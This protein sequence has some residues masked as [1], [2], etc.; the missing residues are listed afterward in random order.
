MLCKIVFLLLS[1]FTVGGCASQP[2]KS[3]SESKSGE[4]KEIP[5]AGRQSMLVS[6][7]NGNEVETIIAQDVLLEVSSIVREFYSNAEPV[8]LYLED[9]ELN[10]LMAKATGFSIKF[11][12]PLQFGDG[13]NN[14]NYILFFTE[15]R[16]RNTD[17][18]SDIY[19]LTAIG[20]EDLIRS[21]FIV[22]GG[23]DNY[24]KLRKLL[25]I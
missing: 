3:G 4:N 17:S 6:Y 18:V 19:F 15:G 23:V 7:T 21:P 1:M 9:D 5:L 11:Q 10:E 24:I 16:F 2:G 22:E 14:M 12:P 13:A 8:R 20:S 25:G